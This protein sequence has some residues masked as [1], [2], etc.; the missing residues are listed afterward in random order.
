MHSIR[1]P[2]SRAGWWA[3]SPSTVP[4]TSNSPP[5]PLLSPIPNDPPPYLGRSIGGMRMAACGGV[6]SSSPLFIPPLLIKTCALSSIG[7]CKAE[8]PASHCPL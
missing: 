8:A 4:L 7:A 1:L 2:G 5:L 6:H 3:G